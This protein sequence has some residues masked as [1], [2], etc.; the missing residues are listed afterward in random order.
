MLA[1]LREYADGDYDFG[2]DYSVIMGVTGL[3]LD[4][5]KTIVSC[6]CKNDSGMYVDCLHI[7]VL[8]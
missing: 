5:A 8:L 3:D 4:D 6:L 1:I 7:L 2:I